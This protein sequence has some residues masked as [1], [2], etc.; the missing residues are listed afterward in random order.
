MNIWRNTLVCNYQSELY[1][2]ASISR[3]TQ[4]KENHSSV[5]RMPRKDTESRSSETMFKSRVSMK[6]RTT[7]DQINS[8]FLK[9][10][11]SNERNKD[12][13]LEALREDMEMNALE[14]KWEFV[15]MA[16]E[17]NK[18]IEET[19]KETEECELRPVFKIINDEVNFVIIREEGDNQEVIPEVVFVKRY[20]A[21]KKQQGTKLAKKEPNVHP[22]DLTKTNMSKTQQGKLNQRDK[23][24]NESL[25]HIM[26]IRNIL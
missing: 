5:Q 11:Y 9:S 6:K 3:I 16:G 24:L 18:W 21:M 13:K 20:K 22:Q 19:G 2:H 26:R 25:L 1:P 7:Y 10:V 14:K 15:V 4:Y 12:H 23:E 8:N 17:M